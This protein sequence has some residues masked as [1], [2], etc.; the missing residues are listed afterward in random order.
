MYLTSGRGGLGDYA[1]GSN[2]DDGA[3]S[4]AARG[5]GAA[6]SDG[7]CVGGSDGRD[8]QTWHLPLSEASI[9][10]GSQGAIDEALFGKRYCGRWCKTPSTRWWRGG[11][12]LLDGILGC[13]SCRMERYVRTHV[14]ELEGSHQFLGVRPRPGVDERTSE[15]ALAR[16]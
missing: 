4:V 14:C 6:R 3:R 8:R 2:G 13:S 7:D 1:G 5:S 16:S 15:T 12:Q 9:G 10:R 11:S